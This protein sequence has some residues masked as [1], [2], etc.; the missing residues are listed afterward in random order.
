MPNVWTIH[1][2]TGGPTKSDLHGLRITTNDAGTAYVLM[3][4]NDL[5][6]SST[7][8]GSLP[9]PPFSFVDFDLDTYTWTLNVNTL[10]G[11]ASSN[12]AQG[13]WTNDAPNPADEQ[14]G[15]FTAQAGSGVG[16]GEAGDRGE[17]TS[18]ASA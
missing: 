7:N 18:A 11:G 4:G 15:T 1:H 10:T 12:E 16:S 6:S 5:L 13:T 9:A 2:E 3:K 14:D 8:N 17:D